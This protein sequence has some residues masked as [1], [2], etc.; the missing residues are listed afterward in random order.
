MQRFNAE[1]LMP[2][3]YKTNRAIFSID[4]QGNIIIELIAY[5][6]KYQ[7]DR[8][9]DMCRISKDGGRIETYQPDSSR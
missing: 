5:K 4:N 2:I 1:R 9:V 7:E 8:V 6:S 3:R